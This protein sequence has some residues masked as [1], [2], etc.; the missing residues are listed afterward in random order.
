MTAN[1]LAVLQNSAVQLSE[2]EQ[3]ILAESAAEDAAFDLIPTKLTI[4]PGGIGVFKSSTGEVMPEL[5]CI[6]AVS[7]KAR[8]YWPEKGSGSPPLCASLDGS[9]GIFNVDAPDK[10]L[11]EAATARDPHIGLRL[12]DAGKPVPD[13]VDCATCPLSQWGS[14]HQ[15]GKEGKAQ[16]CKSLR[17]LVVL[18]DGWTQPAL[19]TLPPTS[20]K[21]FDSY[22]SGL[23]QKRSAYWA[24]RTM[25]TQEAKKSGGGDPY[26]VAIFTTGGKLEPDQLRA[27]IAIRKEYA[28]LVR[29]LGITPD[30]YDDAGTVTANGSDEDIDSAL[31]F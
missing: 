19:L 16:A 1:P 26:G 5:R 9:M 28:A 14:A 10:Q 18:I 4:A 25:I 23:Q 2:E 7:Q 30:E 24:V 6:I 12:L 29:D 13:A 20:I 15:G 22:A 11:K 31:P 27:V 8:A 17:R 21:L 3:L